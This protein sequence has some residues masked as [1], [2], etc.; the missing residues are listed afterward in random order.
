MYT[1][2]EKHTPRKITGHTPP[3]KKKDDG[4]VSRKYAMLTTNEIN[5]PIAKERSAIFS[6]KNFFTLSPAATTSGN[7]EP[8]SL[9]LKKLARK[10]QAR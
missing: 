8:E 6:G 5:T 10:K 4:F 2:A 7:I 3:Q 1:T 9:Y